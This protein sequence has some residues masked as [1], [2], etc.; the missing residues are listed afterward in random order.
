MDLESYLKAKGVWYRF[1]D[2]A[3][4]V[5]TADASRASGIDLHHLT[6]NLVSKTSDGRHTLLIVPGD[7][8]V[9]LQKAARALKVANVQ[10]LGFKEAEMISGYAPGATSLNSSQ[11]RP[12]GRC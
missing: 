7:R 8:R 5:H 10:L 6:K 1:I 12:D 11:D 4:T 2:K 9:N 3:E